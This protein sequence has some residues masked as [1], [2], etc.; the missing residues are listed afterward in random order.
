MTPAP[1]R[2]MVERVARAL[3]IDVEPRYAD[4]A[5]WNWHWDWYLRYRGNG[6]V[7]DSSVQAVSERKARIAIEAM[8]TPNDDMQHAGHI[9]WAED[10]TWE[11][12]WPAMIDAALSAPG[13]ER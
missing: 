5:L 8:R 11:R 12:V 2:A 1:D 6:G 13:D 7:A 3:A 10:D 9:A 4:E